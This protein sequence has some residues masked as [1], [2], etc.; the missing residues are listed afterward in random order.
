MALYIAG[1]EVGVNNHQVIDGTDN[2]LVYKFQQIV[3]FTLNGDTIPT[4]TELEEAEVELQ[5]IYKNVMEGD[6]E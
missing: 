4:D 3:N 2:I 6:D 1:V 5:K